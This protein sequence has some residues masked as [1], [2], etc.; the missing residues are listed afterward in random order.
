MLCPSYDSNVEFTSTFSFLWRTNGSV[1]P[2]ELT[3]HLSLAPIDSQERRLRD[4]MHENAPSPLCWKSNGTVVFLHDVSFFY[5]T[6]S[7][8]NDG[9]REITTVN[10]ETAKT[11]DVFLKHIW[12]YSSSSL[13]LFLSNEKFSYWFLLFSS[14]SG[15]QFFNILFQRLNLRFQLWPFIDCDAGTDHWPSDTT[16]PTECLFAAHE[17]VRNV[18]VFA[19]QGQVHE[20]LNGR[21][22]SS[23]D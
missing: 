10:N 19:Q 4:P 21:C 17:H 9:S 16:G 2:V 13:S 20:N 5:F 6:P 23:H 3:P 15:K 8:T 1:I 11:T 12:F 7:E 18:L 14:F 22:V